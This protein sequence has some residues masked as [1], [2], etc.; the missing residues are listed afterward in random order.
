MYQR[1]VERKQEKIF[2]NFQ[3]SFERLSILKKSN[4]TS[5]DYFTRWK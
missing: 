3:T 1:F 5:N 4:L 2:P